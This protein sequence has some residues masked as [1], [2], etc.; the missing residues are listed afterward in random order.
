MG[1]T[2]R[3]SPAIAPFD[4]AKAK[5]H[6]DAWA[7]H[8]SV[9]PE[10]TNSI[11]MKLRLIPPGEFL[12]GTPANDLLALLEKA[13]KTKALDL[14]IT[15]IAKEGTQHPVRLTQPYYIGTF[16]VTRA[17]FARFV[18]ATGYK[19][20]IERNGKGGWSNHKGE[21]VRRPEH[22]WSTP[23]EW[24]THDDEPVVQVTWNDAKTF[25]DWL[26]ETEGRSYVLPTEAQW[27]FACRAGTTDLTHA[28]PG[29]P[30]KEYAW[31]SETL[32]PDR[33]THHPKPVGLKKKNAFGLHDMLGN[34]WE[35]CSDWYE[36]GPTKPD[37]RID[38]VG[39]KTGSARSIR[40]GAWYREGSIFARCGGRSHGLV[41]GMDS[42]GSDAGIGFRVAIVGDLK[43]RTKPATS[44]VPFF[45]GKDLTGW[46]TELPDKWRVE[47]GAIIGQ[48]NSYLSLTDKK[49]E[50]FH[51]RLEA[52]INADGWG[53]LAIRNTGESHANVSICPE[54]GK[55]GSLFFFN[56][57][58]NQLLQQP[59]KQLA[60]PDTWLTLEV[61][62][63]GKNVV[64]LV[65][66]TQTAEVSID[67]L[68]DRGRILFNADAPGTVIH[69]R[70]I[71]I[72]ELPATPK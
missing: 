21:W 32:L 46:P 15:R 9:E 24:Q 63:Q 43:A 54:R 12:M 5:E 23:G 71:E 66:G 62:V 4:A 59:E 50:N 55:T 61:I 6:Q 65:N 17:Q 70:K 19:T 3:P 20:D 31:T 37:L 2:P 8:L 38:P 68:P 34:A 7:K 39:P 25:C 36:S 64:V 72:K 69:F 29:R 28:E 57:G 16:E 51:C 1:R 14:E 18:Q 53:G 35:H 58:M 60:S 48:G 42:E 52:K 27:E 26:S 22:V 49:F 45:N 40:G 41:F 11:G 47:N 33:A 67:G 44:W 10:T 13:R 56:N 30:L